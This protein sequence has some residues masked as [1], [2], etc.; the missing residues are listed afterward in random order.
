MVIVALNASVSQVLTQILAILPAQ[1]INDPR[2]PIELILYNRSNLRGNSLRTLG[3]HLIFDIP[4]VEATP[5][6]LHV[7]QLQGFLDVLLHDFR[8]SSGKANDRYIREIAPE[9]RELLVI[10]AEVVAPLGNAMGLVDDEPSQF[11]SGV[12]G[13]NVAQDLG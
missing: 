5:E 1:T 2:L 9:T 12:D 13:L 4:S 11:S 3:E 8:G 6:H 10:L 7:L